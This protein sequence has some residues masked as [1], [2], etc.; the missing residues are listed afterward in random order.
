MT[1]ELD[2]FE[3]ALLNQLRDEV[4]TRQPRRAR[5]GRRLAA[6]GVAAAAAAIAGVLIVPGL[7]TAP[8]FSVQ[9]GNAGEIRVEI[10]APEDAAGLERALE[11]HGIAADITYLPELQ[12]CAPGRYREI[13]RKSPGMVIAIGDDHIAVTLPPGTIRA[14][15]TFVLTWSAVPMTR[16]ELESDLPEGVTSEQGTHVSGAFGIARGDVAAC[17]P[18]AGQ[19]QD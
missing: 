14:G 7:G 16:A 5:P 13:T 8:A 6:L 18:V 15:E 10:N 1:T 9:E 3:T 19:S 12:T 11:E 4:A 17:I 2:S